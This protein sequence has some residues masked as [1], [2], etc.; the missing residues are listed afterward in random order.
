MFDRPE[1]PLNSVFVKL[2][3]RVDQKLKRPYQMNRRNSV[4]SLGS[5]RYKRTMLHFKCSYTCTR[6][7]ARSRDVICVT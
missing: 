7:H 1:R 3:Q 4:H 2:D 5:L 6:T